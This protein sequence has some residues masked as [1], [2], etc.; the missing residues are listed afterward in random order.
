MSL[1]VNSIINSE[2]LY[3]LKR[4]RELEEKLNDCFLCKKETDRIHRELSIIYYKLNFIENVI[5]K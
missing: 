4:K 1:K 5:Q 2:K 3:L